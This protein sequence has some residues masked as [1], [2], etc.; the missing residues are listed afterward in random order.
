MARRITPAAR[1]KRAID[2]KNS[3]DFM[4]ALLEI[5]RLEYRST[6]TFR[7]LTATDIKNILQAITSV[8][9]DSNSK[10]HSGSASIHDLREYLKK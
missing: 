2:T 9:S 8:T 6:G 4:W 10:S 3:L 5:A 1:M 7:T